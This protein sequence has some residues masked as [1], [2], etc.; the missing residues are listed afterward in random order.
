[1]PPGDKVIMVGIQAVRPGNVVHAH[2]VTPDELNRRRLSFGLR[3]IK[4]ISCP[5]FS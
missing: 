1:V 2:E 3:S 4:L 5:L